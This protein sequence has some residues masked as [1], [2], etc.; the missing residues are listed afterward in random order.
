MGSLFPIILVE[1][2]TNS[3]FIPHHISGMKN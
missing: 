1:R 3:V 2:T